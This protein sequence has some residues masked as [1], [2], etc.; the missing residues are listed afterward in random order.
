MH[1]VG[2]LSY[3]TIYISGEPLNVQVDPGSN[4]L[5]VYSDK[6][7]SAACQHIATKYTEPSSDFK[8]VASNFALARDYGI[9]D[10]VLGAYSSIHRM[11]IVT[12][13]TGRQRL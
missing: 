1:N 6:C 8:R 11:H 7:N 12:I 10:A 2:R 9:T 13:L 5:W 3:V 4:E